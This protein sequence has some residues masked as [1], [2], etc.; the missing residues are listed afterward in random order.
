MSEQ[1]AP[2]PGQEPKP[3]GEILEDPDQVIE[4]QGDPERAAEVQRVDLDDELAAK[5][6]E[7]DELWEE[8]QAGRADEGA[9]ERYDALKRSMVEID[10]DRFQARGE[11]GGKPSD[12]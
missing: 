3:I 2:D 4:F 10:A 7:I 8:I 11:Q 12:K 6:L 5:Q 9:L 1:S